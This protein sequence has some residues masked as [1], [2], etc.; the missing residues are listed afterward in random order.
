MKHFIISMPPLVKRLLVAIADTLSVFLSV[1]LAYTIRLDVIHVPMTIG[2]NTYVLSLLIAIPIFSKFG[3]YDAVFRFVGNDAIWTITKAVFYYGIIFFL[4]ILFFDYFLLNQ[5]NFIPKSLGIIQPLI[6]LIIICSNRLFAR[7]LLHSNALVIN[8]NKRC[9]LI[10]GAGH[11]GA[12]VGN[13]LKNNRTYNLI[14]YLDDDPNLQHRTIHGLMVYSSAELNYLVNKYAVTDVLLALPFIDQSKRNEILSYLQSFHLHI[15]SLPKMVDLA[16]GMFMNF[17]FKELDENDLLCRVPINPNKELLE[18][19]IKNKVVM[20]TGA[21]GSIGSELAQEILICN[22]KILIL[23]EQS[24]YALYLIEGKLKKQINLIKLDINLISL[25]GNVQDYDWLSKICKTWNI[26]TIYHAAAYKHVPI[27]EHNIIQGLLNNVWGTLN[28]I[29]VSI[30]NNLQ[31]CV[32][33]STDKAVRPTNIMGASKRLAEMIV[34]AFAAQSDTH[35]EFS[36]VRFGNVLGSSGSVVPLF[37]AQINAGGPV[38][39]T[40][41][42]VTRYFMTTK[43]A[44]QLVIQAGGIRSHEAQRNNCPIFLLEMGSP[45]KILSLAKRMI[46]L[47]GYSVKDVNNPSG[48]IEIVYIGLRS[49]EKLHEEL[50]ID[51]SSES[52]IHSKIYRANER[53]I[54]LVEL[55]KHLSFLHQCLLVGDVP[56]TYKFLLRIISGFTPDAEIVDYFS[57]KKSNN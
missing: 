56:N 17:D 37:R 30:E 2:F 31:H 42:E 3:L 44:A 6:L 23:F 16:E 49:G 21:G 45:I 48:D 15:R 1:W 54:P 46:E 51:H 20:V 29:R 26:D 35:V 12:Q 19:N 40:H 38:T 34:Q 11:E 57:R 18:K 5:I 52:T 39:L 36:I 43:E 24:E 22:P 32:F 9:L 7:S 50:F 41:P 28:I 4:S 27:V 8:K 13:L 14:G 10:Y 33:V 55:E 53:F 47:S 25:L